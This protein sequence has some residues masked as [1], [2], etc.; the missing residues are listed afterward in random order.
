MKTAL[1]YV[2]DLG[3]DVGE[4]CEWIDVVKTRGAK[5]AEHHCGALATAI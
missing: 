1:G 2:V 3:E 4:P 5:E